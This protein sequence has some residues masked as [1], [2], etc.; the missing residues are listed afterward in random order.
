MLLKE[1]EIHLRE[2][3]EPQIESGTN[4]QQA[5]ENSVQQVGHAD[6][7]K[8]EFKKIGDVT[9][10]AFILGFCCEH[11]PE[12]ARPRMANCDETRGSRRFGGAQEVR[13]LLR[14]G[15]SAPDLRRRKAGRL[16][17]AGV[18]RTGR[19]FGR[20]CAR[21]PVVAE[22]MTGQRALSTRVAPRGF[23]LLNSCFFLFVGF[24]AA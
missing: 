7:L 11:V 4:P 17:M 1:L 23:F 13:L 12:R 16:G 20:G 9:L 22:A 8:G 14:R 5:F 19:E 2:E 15:F 21:G 6:E 3:I 10:M 18:F 24:F